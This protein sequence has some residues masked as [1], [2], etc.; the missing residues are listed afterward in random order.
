VR[1]TANHERDARHEAVQVDEAFD[2]ISEPDDVP[3]FVI[4][5]Y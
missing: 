4:T 1:C 3:I 5:A 2:A